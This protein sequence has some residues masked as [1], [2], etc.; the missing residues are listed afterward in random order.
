M[1]WVGLSRSF[2]P[3]LVLAQGC[4]LAVSSRG[5]SSVCVCLCSRSSYKDPSLRGLGLILVTSFHLN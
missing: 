4:P 2:F 5:L 3:C 1:A